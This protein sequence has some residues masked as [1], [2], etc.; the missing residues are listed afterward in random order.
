M[1]R[2]NFRQSLRDS[3]GLLHFFH[4]QHFDGF[5][6]GHEF[7]AELVVQGAFESILV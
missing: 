6:A 5:A 2:A 7:E 4:H 1:C 3:F